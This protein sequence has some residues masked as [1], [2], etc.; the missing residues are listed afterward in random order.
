SLAS[1]HVLLIDDDLDVH[2]LVTAM[3]KPLGA[4]VS[5][6]ADPASGLARARME[7]P[8]LMLLDYDM[9]GRSGL[10]LLT[11]LRADSR[12]ARIPVSMVTGSD[13]HMVLE[14]CFSAG[15]QDYIHKPFFAAEL[16]A[17]VGSAIDRQ[18]LLLD[19]ERAAQRDRLTGLP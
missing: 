16:R 3:L 4:R 12:L 17:R 10:S 11:E 8:D 1:S 18:R 19:A 7:M 6:A 5:V 2:E 15:A 14:S 9:P 13:G